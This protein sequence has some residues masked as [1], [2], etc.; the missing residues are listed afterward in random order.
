[1]KDCL[2][3]GSHPINLNDRHVMTVDPEI[4]RSECRSIKNTQTVRFFPEQT[5][6]LHLC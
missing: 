6:E 5:A 4:K 2:I 1:M 3:I